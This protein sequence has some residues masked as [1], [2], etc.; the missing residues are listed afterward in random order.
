[1]DGNLPPQAK[2]LID[3]GIAHL[4]QKED[5]V[6]F[7]SALRFEESLT[8]DQE[9]YVKEML[10]EMH[11]TDTQ[12]A[13][14]VRNCSVY[15]GQGFAKVFVE[16]LTD[17]LIGVREDFVEK[18][19]SRMAGVFPE[20]TTFTICQDNPYESDEIG[21]D[22]LDQ[23]RAGKPPGWIQQWFPDIISVSRDTQTLMAVQNV[24]EQHRTEIELLSDDRRRNLI[25][26]LARAALT[27]EPDEAVKTLLPW[28]AR[29]EAELHSNRTWFG[30]LR[31]LLAETDRD[32]N[33]VSS[34]LKDLLGLK[35]EEG[36]F[37]TLGDQL[38]L[39]IQAIKEFDSDSPLMKLD[40]K[41]AEVTQIRNE[42]AHGALFDDKYFSKRWQDVLGLLLKFV[43]L[44][45]AIKRRSVAGM[46]DRNA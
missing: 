35:R 18:V 24:L 17:N 19:L 8:H 5:G 33:E 1:M 4:S 40:P 25:A 12:P 7:F 46:E 20:I 23:F 22:A 11:Q 41:P 28:F 38:N 32:V 30:F 27:F 39:Y 43:A 13:R 42:F 36:K 34:Y 3:K 16:G 26:P 45:D 6:R 31:A 29:V 10:F 9:T 21:R 44:Y 15:W 14:R 2:A 37:I